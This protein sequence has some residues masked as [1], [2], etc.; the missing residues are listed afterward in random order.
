M[1]ALSSFLLLAAGCDD[2]TS[3]SDAAVPD[4]AVPDL[5]QAGT[6][7]G[8]NFDCNVDFPCRHQGRCVDEATIIQCSTF[9]CHG[10]CGDYPWCPQL[11]MSE[12]AC[13]SGC[14]CR[15]GGPTPCPA[16]TRCFETDI[17]GG[18]P[19]AIGAACLSPDAGTSWHPPRLDGGVASCSF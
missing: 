1:V 10:R 18:L 11:C 12:S 19:G 14:I 6:C 5:A 17:S 15:Q 9:C 4:L 16:G 8:P 2:A 3:S 13:C 7:T